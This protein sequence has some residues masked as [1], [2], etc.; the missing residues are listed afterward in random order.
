VDA[1]GPAAQRTG[2]FHEIEVKSRQLEVAS[3]HKVVGG[4]LHDGG[5]HVPIQVDAVLDERGIGR[6]T[7]DRQYSNDWRAGCI[8]CASMLMFR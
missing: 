4:E 6:C 7:V 3:Q 5:A 1:D 8:G 2:H